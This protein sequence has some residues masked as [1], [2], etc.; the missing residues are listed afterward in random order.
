MEAYQE[1]VIAGNTRLRR[2]EDS[3]VTIA[4]CDGNLNHEVRMTTLRVP[5]WDWYTGG[6]RLLF[7][8]TITTSWSTVRVVWSV[9][10]WVLHG[11]FLFGNRT[12]S[13][14][15][16]LLTKVQSIRVDCS[17]AKR[18]CCF[19]NWWRR[20]LRV[21]KVSTIVLLF[22]THPPIPFLFV[23]CLCRGLA[24]SALCDDPA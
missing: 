13:N 17:R 5:L 20:S 11:L 18:G 19:I 24:G 2:L 23:C 8:F 3:C 1:R 6:K 21:R 7:W 9:R 4:T 12:G 22:F 10:E 15:R 14:M 16:L